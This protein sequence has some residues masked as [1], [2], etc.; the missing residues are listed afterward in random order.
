MKKWIAF[1]PTA[2]LVASLPVPTFA[3]KATSTAPN[4]TVEVSINTVQ[5]VVEG[6][7]LEL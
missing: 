3:E 6:Y 1:P 2:V 7:S 4:P 5:V